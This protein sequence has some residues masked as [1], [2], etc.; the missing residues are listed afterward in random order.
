MRYYKA[1]KKNKEAPYQHEKTIKIIK[2]QKQSAE[3]S[4]CYF[5]F[6]NKKEY[7]WEEYTCISLFRQKKNL[8]KYTRN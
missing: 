7:V 5:F 1:V 6:N 4:V 2:V 8:E 3:W